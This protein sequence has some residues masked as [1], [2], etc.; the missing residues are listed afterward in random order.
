MHHISSSVDAHLAPLELSFFPRILS[1]NRQNCIVSV[2]DFISLL[3]SRN[4]ENIV[5]RRR[6]ISRAPPLVRPDGPLQKE[7]PREAGL[8]NWLESVVNGP[9]TTVFPCECVRFVLISRSGFR[10]KSRRSLV[11]RL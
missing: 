9:P 11:W 4:T 2:C 10:G 7:Q 3:L 5:D 8:V 6:L 1:I